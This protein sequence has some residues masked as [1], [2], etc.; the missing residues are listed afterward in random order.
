[1]IFRK[2]IASWQDGVVLLWGAN[3]IS[4]S[5][6]IH[7]YQS[8]IACQ[9]IR[10]M[11]AL[12]PAFTACK[13][14]P[15]GYLLLLRQLG[16][17]HKT[18]SKRKESSWP[19]DIEGRC[20]L[21]FWPSA[22]PAT[23]WTDRCLHF[24]Q[25]ETNSTSTVPNCFPQS[26]CVESASRQQA[27]VCVSIHTMLPPPSPDH[28]HPSLHFVCTGMTV[29]LCTVTWDDGYIHSVH[30]S[31]PLYSLHCMAICIHSPDGSQGKAERGFAPPQ[32]N[33]LLPRAPKST[34]SDLCTLPSQHNTEGP[35]CQVT[36]HLNLQ[37]YR[38]CVSSTAHDQ[39][40]G[41]PPPPP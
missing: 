22:A 3:E 39:L 29:S 38:D 19:T 2:Y 12:P 37:A 31:Q 28:H 34:G 26:A 36:D 16:C 6:P 24:L 40:S 17:S 21:Q 13:K 15:R 5:F 32:P 8:G 1:M 7:E 23:A 35:E 18:I 4:L 20:R 10:P 11:E 33:S 41:P 30:G 25:Q 14:K 9:Y 27:Q